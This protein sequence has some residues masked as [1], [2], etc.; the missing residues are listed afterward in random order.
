MDSKE[1]FT[2]LGTWMY[3]DCMG[4][5]DE[6]CKFKEK[7]ELGVRNLEIFNIDLLEKGK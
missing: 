5:V 6:I 3:E 2:G 1:I 7:G 4:L